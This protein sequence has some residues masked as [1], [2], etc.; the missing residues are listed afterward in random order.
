MFE[1]VQI[2]VNLGK[3][4]AGKWRMERP[5]VSQASQSHGIGPGCHSEQWKR[6]GTGSVR[7]VWVSP[8][9]S[10]AVTKGN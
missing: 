6:I 2:N 5:Q 1:R 4:P 3:S 7:Q 10:A 8:S 9:S